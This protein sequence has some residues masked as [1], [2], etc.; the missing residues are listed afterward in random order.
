PRHTGWEND[1]HETRLPHSRREARAR[2][3]PVFF[4]RSLL[5]AET[6]TSI[7]P[8][9]PAALPSRGD[10]EDSCNTEGR[11]HPE[12]L[13]ALEPLAEQRCRLKAE[14]ARWAARRRRLLKEA[15]DY[16]TE[17]EPHDQQLIG[18]AKEL[19]DCFLWM[20]HRDGPSPEDLSLFE[21]L[22][23][24]FETMAAAIGLL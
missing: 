4:H 1:C 18:R 3:V 22:A 21:D 2:P 9:R 16:A 20:C 19:P 6:T 11:L 23:G 17:I 8:R 24:C 14:G 7:W 12:F 10:F 15:A 13:S 5:T